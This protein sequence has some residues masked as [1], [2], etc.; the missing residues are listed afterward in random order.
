[1]T[2]MIQIRNVPD[3]IHR[4]L[5]MK[6]AKEGISLSEFL[7]REASRAAET[8]TLREW[9]DM[10]A[11]NPPGALQSSADEIV[12]SIREGH[13]ERDRAIDEAMRRPL[14]DK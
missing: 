7:L 11:Q 14:N 13:E 6:A 9:L 2:K 12:D 4:K 8:P 1:M 10:V 3:D 5:K